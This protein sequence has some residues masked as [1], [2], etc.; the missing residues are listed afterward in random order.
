[1]RRFFVRLLPRTLCLCSVF[2]ISS[3][4]QT[5]HA[6]QKN[7]FRDVPLDHFAYSAIEQLNREQVMQG[8]PDGTFK[9][10]RVLT[11]YELAVIVAKILARIE[12]HKEQA[13]Q[14]EVISPQSE[15]LVGRLS[16]E[17]RA[18]LDMLGVRIDSLEKRVLKVEEDTK[19]LDRALSNVHV[20][21]FYVG[22]QKFVFRSNKF[23]NFDEPGLHRLNQDVF[24]RFIGNPKGEEGIFAKNIEAFMELKGN[25]SGKASNRLLY[26]FSDK[27]IAGE[28]IDDFAT[29]IQDDRHVMVNKVHFKSKAPL[30]DLRIF[31]GEQFTDLNDPATLLTAST[32]ATGSNGIMSGIE[33]SGKYKKWTYFTSV[34]KRTRESGSPGGSLTNLYS[35][36][37]KTVDSDQDVFSFRTTFQPLSFEDRG[38]E[39]QL[40]LGG[41]FVETTDDYYQLNDF[42][43]VIGWDM[44]YSAEAEKTNFD[45]TLNSLVSEGNGDIHDSGFKA[46]AQYENRNLLVT[47]KGYSFGKDFKTNVGSFQY[48]DTEGGANYGRGATTGERLLRGQM[49]YTFEDGQLAAIKN[50]TMTL[51]GQQKWWEKLVGQETAPWY[52]RRGT[53]LALRTVADFH[54]NVQLDLENEVKKD[55][56]PDEK[57][58]TR[59]TLNFGWKPVFFAGVRG[60][61]EFISDFDEIVDNQHFTR[62]QAV[63]GGGTALHRRFIIK[64]VLV[65]RVDWSGRPNQIDVDRVQAEFSYDILPDGMLSIKPQW[66]RQTVNASISKASSNVTDIFV[67]ELNAN[68]SKKLEGRAAYGWQH[69]EN[70]FTRL[71]DD[72]WNWFG[73]LVYEPTNSTE[74]VLRYGY[75]YN[76]RSHP[77][78]YD[79]ENTRQQLQLRA[80]TDF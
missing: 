63:L 65:D 54:Q 55:A 22:S 58:R 71:G 9:G 24:L 15:V 11:R 32:F 76:D 57:G 50:L 56:R 53:K 33:A 34:L 42:N 31:M 70:L 52:G 28:N 61:L 4:L 10:R 13:P 8:Y 14:S 79:F 68:F 1:M 66:R 26:S 17:F 5:S 43:R 27:P 69:Q 51:T 30:M 49:K 75:D 36:F 21:G 60:Q 6:Q 39:K 46:D 67:T 73:E 74:I 3:M 64:G 37:N 12:Q 44:N 78:I 38:W 80:Q 77:E 47:M 2:A 20:E 7:P 19:A 16:T 18:E 25:L 48:V 23:V 59:H 35:E 72:Y 41:S 62:Q 45:L 29:G 40:T